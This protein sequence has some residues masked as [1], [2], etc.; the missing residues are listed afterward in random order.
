MVLSFSSWFSWFFCLYQQKKS[1]ESKIKFRQVNNCRRRVLEAAKLAYDKKQRSLSHSRTLA[2]AT[3]GEMLIVVTKVT[4]V[5]RCYVL[6]L[7]YQNCLLKTFMETLIL[8][9]KVSL[10]LF[11]PIELI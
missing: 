6:H 10:Y 1:P 11:S 9:T 4:T 5:P 8:M 7:I 2:L 3:F